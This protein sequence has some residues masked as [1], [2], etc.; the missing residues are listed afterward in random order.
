MARVWCAVGERFSAHVE[1]TGP[2]TEAAAPRDS[3]RAELGGVAL[4]T[5][6]VGDSPPFD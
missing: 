3:W 1:V 5:L 2:R 4:L 6:G